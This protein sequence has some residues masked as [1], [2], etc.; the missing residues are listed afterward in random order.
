MSNGWGKADM[1]LY[2]ILYL[3]INL[4]CVIL[5]GI[6]LYKTQGLSRMVAQRLFSMTICS[7]IAF[8]L[9]DTLYVLINH[10]ILIRNKFWMM[11]MKEIYFFSTS[12]MCFF[13]FAYFEHLLKSTFI[14]K[15]N[16]YLYAS[17]L[18]WLNGALLL[19]NPFIKILFY[20]N[21]DGVYTRG[22]LFIMLYLFAYSYIAAA[23]IHALLRLRREEDLTQRSFL[24]TLV[25]F[26]VA[27]C[28]AGIVQFIR[29]E[30]PL[31]C[32]ALSLSTLVMYLN[33]M[34]ETVSLDPL[35]RLNNRKQLLHYYEQW[36]R[37]AGEWDSIYFLLID[38]NRF[39][40]IND[41]YGHTEGDAALV[42]IADALR[43]S[44]R[45]LPRRANIARYGGDEFIILTE[46]DSEEAI[47]RFREE[48][49]RVLKERNDADGAPYP[50][51]VSVGIT[52]AYRRHAFKELLHA[53]D[54]AMYEEKK[55]AHGN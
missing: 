51:T 2:A 49:D 19:L 38:A 12:L 24:L 43:L 41:T 31:A 42:R 5:I 44:C 10:G 21:A 18:V 34:D 6:V 27:P 39:K 9:S 33:W 28:L 15:K 16:S 3:E 50:L 22:P 7:E 13:W 55:R 45:T 36:R 20:I 35:T 37:N 29:P 8:F 1:T 32:V 40:S 48:I 54:E 14:Q 25:L 46:A 26:P 23:A 47:R 11:T 17:L 52:K 53:S 30:L 4:A